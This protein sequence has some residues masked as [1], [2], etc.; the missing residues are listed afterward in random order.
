MPDT[1]RLSPPSPPSVRPLRPLPAFFHSLAIP[2]WAQA[3][4]DRKLT[5]SLFVLWEGVT[6]GM[7]LKAATEVRYLER[8]AADSV[9]IDGKKREQQDWLFLLLFNH[10]FSGLEAYVSSQLQDFPADVH[11][12]A[13]PRGFGVGVSVPL[14]WP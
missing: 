1:I 3:K 6:L 2:G 13:L 10:L 4:L 11:F 9:R 5:A 12:R 14:R 8:I 7:T